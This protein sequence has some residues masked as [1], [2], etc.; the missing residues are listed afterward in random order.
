MEFGMKNL[1]SM[2]S[3][4]ICDSP[5]PSI[6]FGEINGTLDLGWLRGTLEWTQQPLTTAWIY[7]LKHQLI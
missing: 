3:S 2:V 1:D 4:M 7:S 5:L 6:R